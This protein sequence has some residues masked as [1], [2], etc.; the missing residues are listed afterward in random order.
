MFIYQQGG[1][2]N[3]STI[4]SQF[5]EIFQVVNLCLQSSQLQDNI[6]LI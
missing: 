1:F 6:K 3:T 4:Q 5:T 2:K